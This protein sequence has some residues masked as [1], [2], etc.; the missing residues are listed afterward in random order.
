MIQMRCFHCGDPIAN[1]DD[2]R[3]DQQVNIEYRT[4]RKPECQEKERE[5]KACERERRDEANA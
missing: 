4:C 2:G 3:G 1:R 5:W